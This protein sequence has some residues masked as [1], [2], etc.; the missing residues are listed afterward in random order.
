MAS[1]VT[2]GVVMPVVASVITAVLVGMASAYLTAT[3]TAVR[4]DEKISAMTVRL[5]QLEEQ[6][7]EQRELS[8]KIIRIEAK[9][10]AIIDR[11]ERQE[12]YT[13]PYIA[14]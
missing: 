13:G 12:R 6:Q 9:L 8:D 1:E 7:T 2:S 3:T 14:K 4:M 11:L 10:D 5:E